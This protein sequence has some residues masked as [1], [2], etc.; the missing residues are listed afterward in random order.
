MRR[1][2]RWYVENV[3]RG[4]VLFKIA[5]L[6]N[7]VFMV[8][9]IAYICTERVEFLFWTCFA[10]WL[11]ISLVNGV[12]QIWKS[13]KAI[14]DSRAAM[15]EMDR[16][17]QEPLPSASDLPPEIQEEVRIAIAKNILK[18]KDPR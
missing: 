5:T 15:A 4:G 2:I 9:S 12:H 6:A 17:L 18:D 13:S 8:V 7:V 10:I 3:G 14:K 16:I 11:P 1:A